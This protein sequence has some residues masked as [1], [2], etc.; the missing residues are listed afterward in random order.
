MEKFGTIANSTKNYTMDDLQS[1][2]I[3]IPKKQ[4]QVRFSK[5]IIQEQVDII[6]EKFDF[7]HGG[8]KRKKRRK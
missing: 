7:S 1:S 2:K 5:D 6:K 4:K 8:K 3:I